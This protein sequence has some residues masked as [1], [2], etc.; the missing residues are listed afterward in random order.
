MIYLNRV[1][2]MGYL[3]ED[4]RTFVA[5]SSGRKYVKFSLATTK[6][7]KDKATGNAVD[8]TQWHSVTAWAKLAETLDRI[9][10]AKGTPVYVDGEVS[11][12]RWTDSDG[13]V[14]YATDIVASRVQS[15]STR[16]GQV[17][18]SASQNCEDEDLPF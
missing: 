1:E 4:A 11:Y 18:A 8:H 16:Q 3:G 12:R 2:L 9:K 5:A 14:K 13:V 6:R 7:T 17:Q 15:L 10:L